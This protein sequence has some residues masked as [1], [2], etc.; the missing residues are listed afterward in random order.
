MALLAGVWWGGGVAVAA[1]FGTCR[2]KTLVPLE[3]S[4]VLCGFS[5][6]L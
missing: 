1:A 6:L 2:P 5:G 4:G 3:F